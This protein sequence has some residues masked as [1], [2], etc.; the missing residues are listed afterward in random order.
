MQTQ[1]RTPEKLLATRSMHKYVWIGVSLWMTFVITFAIAYLRVSQSQR[2]Q[3]EPF[4]ALAPH[5]TQKP[6][7]SY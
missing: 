7:S 6:A 4:Q 3:G 1:I 2:F 5:E